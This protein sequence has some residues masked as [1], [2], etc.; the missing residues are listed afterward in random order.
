MNLLHSIASNYRLNRRL[1][2]TGFAYLASCLL[3]RFPW[4]IGW[5]PPDHQA[6]VFSLADTIRQAAFFVILFF[7]KDKT[8]S[9]NGTAEK[10][11]RIAGKGGV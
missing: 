11:Y 5:M 4:L 10:P 7:V 6:Q 9:G 3:L 8:V 1:W 2:N